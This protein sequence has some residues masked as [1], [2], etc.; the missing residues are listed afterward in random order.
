MLAQAVVVTGVLDVRP[1]EPDGLHYPQCTRCKRFLRCEIAP[2]DAVR[3]AAKLA[4][5]QAAA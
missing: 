3:D 2:P 1:S 5:V 4:S